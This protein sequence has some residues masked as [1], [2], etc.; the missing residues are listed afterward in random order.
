M[1]KHFNNFTS[2]FEALLSAIETDKFVTVTNLDSDLPSEYDYALEQE[3]ED[4]IVFVVR[5][6]ID[7]EYLKNVLV[8]FEESKWNFIHKENPLPEDIMERIKVVSSEKRHS[9]VTEASVFAD[10]NGNPYIAKRLL[11]M[12]KL[13]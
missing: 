5:N 13:G 9:Y 6:I 4:E 3:L 8:K 12:D 10:D 7:L 2:F 1:I 11:V